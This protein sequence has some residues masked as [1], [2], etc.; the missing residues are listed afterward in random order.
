[1]D[2]YIFAAHAT[3]DAVSTLGAG[4]GTT[5]PARVVLPVIGG[6]R[7]YVAV[8]GDDGTE[9]AQRVAAV[10][11][12]EGLSGVRTFLATTPDPPS[13]VSSGWPPIRFPTFAAVAA[14]VGFAAVTTVPG[15]GVSVYVAAAAVPG[16]IGAAVVTGTS[17]NLLVEA[18]G[19]TADEVAAVLQQ[20]AALP[21]VTALS[22]SIGLTAT[23]Y[24]FTTR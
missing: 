21:G 5:G 14:S 2:A 11:A 19:D 17:A 24:G 18:T 20:V 15:L 16:V 6:E 9:L 1:M 7:L 8:E 13:S 23:G 10:A 22:T 12:T 4:V 3:E